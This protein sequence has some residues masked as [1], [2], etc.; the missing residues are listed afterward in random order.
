M[1][2]PKG[3]P[4]SEENE[5][6]GYAEFTVNRV[7]DGKIKMQRLLLVLFY[8]AFAV[9]YCIVFL[10]IWQ[11]ATLVA[12]LP[13]LLLILWLVTW[14]STKIEYTYIVCKG[15][16]Y[17]YRVNGYRRAREVFHAKINESERICPAG[18]ADVKAA[19]LLDFSVGKGKPD[20]YVG[21]FPSEKGRTAVYF[22]AASRL[23]SS[24]RYYGADKVTVCPVS[25]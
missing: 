4:F 25:H 11:L 1:A 2:R 5:S 7:P 16:F 6:L 15:Q 21:M 19:V 9:A 14:R 24:L 12:V 3:I 8:L 17:I 20:L 22:T 13:L 10:V 23:L 18:E